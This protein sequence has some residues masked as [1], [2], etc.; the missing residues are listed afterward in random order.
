MPVLADCNE[1][2]Y[3]ITSMINPFDVD[4]VIVGLN[5]SVSV[6]RFFPFSIEISH[7]NYRIH[8]HTCKHDTQGRIRDRELSW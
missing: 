2:P 8:V 4:E 5:S 3:H 1:T 7:R 6:Y